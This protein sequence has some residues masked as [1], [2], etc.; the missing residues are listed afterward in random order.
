[1]AEY[2]THPFEEYREHARHLRNTAFDTR[3]AQDW[4]TIENPQG[5]PTHRPPEDD[6]TF[7]P[8]RQRPLPALVTLCRMTTTTPSPWSTREGTGGP[9]PGWDG[10]T[11]AIRVRVLP[12]GTSAFPGFGWSWPTRKARSCG[13][14]NPIRGREVR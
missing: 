8:G 5:Q 11:H 9:G 1:M 7:F 4:D 10:R 2:V 14:R 13:P 6:A 12:T 3:E